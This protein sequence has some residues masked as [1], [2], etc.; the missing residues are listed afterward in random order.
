MVG[1]RMENEA[2]EGH[3]LKH[4]LIFRFDAP[5]SRDDLMSEDSAPRATYVG[6]E[7]TGERILVKSPGGKA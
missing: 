2:M 4:P 1:K 5:E 3:A 6:A 7:P